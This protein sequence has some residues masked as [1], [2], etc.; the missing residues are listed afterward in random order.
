MNGL[1]ASNTI[2]DVQELTNYIPDY[3]YYTDMRN[4]S[5]IPYQSPQLDNF[6]QH[7]YDLKRL[8]MPSLSSMT[9]S[10]DLHSHPPS[11]DIQWIPP[12]HL[13]PSYNQLCYVNKM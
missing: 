6:S 9:L 3:S 13:L 7:I 10:N 4:H 12:S 1:P 5:N 8:V 2:F 11:A